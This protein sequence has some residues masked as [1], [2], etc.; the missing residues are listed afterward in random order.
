MSTVYPHWTLALFVNVVVPVALSAAGYLLGMRQR[1]HAL[2]AGRET[3]AGAPPPEAHLPDVVKV[4]TVP[5]FDPLPNQRA[6]EAVAGAAPM[7]LTTEEKEVLL[8]RVTDMFNTCFMALP[9]PAPE[10]IV[11]MMCT[12]RRELF[13]WVT[14]GDDLADEWF[15]YVCGRGRWR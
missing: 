12:V 10:R 1:S 15:D 3:V 9:F 4:G 7:T 8:R 5:T 11:D 13:D 14:D 2:A 6:R